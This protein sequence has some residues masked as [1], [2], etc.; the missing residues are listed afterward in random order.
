MGTTKRYSKEVRERA[1]R[2][3]REQQAEH[4]SQWAAISSIAG[5][6]GCTAESLRR[7]VR[8]E[9]RDHGERAGLSSSE[10]ERLKA[11]ERENRELTGPAA[12][13]RAAAQPAVGRG[14]HLRGDLAGICV[15][16]VRDRRVRTHDRRRA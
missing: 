14:L 5:K 6:M 13:Q 12:I 8:Q 11:L 15:R 1:V 9:E 2:L 10:R 3:V 7:W 16:R 4:G